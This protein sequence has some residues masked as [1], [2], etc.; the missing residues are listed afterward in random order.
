ME[1]PPLGCPIWNTPTHECSPGGEPAD[2]A[3]P[4]NPHIFSP[5]FPQDLTRQLPGNLEVYNT[6]F[7]VDNKNS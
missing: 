7:K 2:K 6:K 3:S 4:T 1:W 5:V